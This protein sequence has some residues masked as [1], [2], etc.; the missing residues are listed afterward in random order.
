[1]GFFDKLLRTA[2]NVSGLGIIP[3][4]DPTAGCDI[5]CEARVV[6][7]AD[8]PDDG[9]PDE[10]DQQV[11]L[12]R[13][14]AERPDG[15]HEGC[16]RQDIPPHHRAALVPGARVIVR[17]H[18]LERGRLYVMWGNGPNGASIVER[19]LLR[20]PGPDRWPHLNSIEVFRK[21]EKRDDRLAQWRAERTAF[22]GQFAGAHPTHSKMNGRRVYELSL[23]TNQG[24]VALRS[25]MPE[26]ALARLLHFGQVRVGAPIVVLVS[27]N[28]K[29]V[30]VDWEA[31]IAQPANWRGGAE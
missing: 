14:V 22:I 23:N 10:F 20:W 26:L 21:G 4:P 16:V 5:R 3:G 9:G 1:M 24:P 30:D 8:L 15:E 18:P 31:T 19:Q 2:D 25:Q 11:S 28:G 7:L 6:G 13:L 29:E 12:L 27:P 17:T